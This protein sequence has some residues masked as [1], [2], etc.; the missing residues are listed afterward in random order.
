MIWAV[1]AGLVVVFAA[2]LILTGVQRKQPTDKK[3]LMF[4]TLAYLKK[5]PG[6]IAI[7]PDPEADRVMLVYDGNFD[8][9]FQKIARSAALRLSNEM[10]VIEL[11]LARNRIEH[12]VYSIRLKG[13]DV[14]SEQVF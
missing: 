7:L 4:D 1:A 13:G 2:F 8:G 6:I 9:D 10:S 14:V 3:T 11:T 12:P 5:V